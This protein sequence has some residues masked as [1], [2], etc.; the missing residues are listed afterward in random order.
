M[1]GRGKLSSGKLIVCNK[2]LPETVRDVESLKERASLYGCSQE[3]NSALRK[4]ESSLGKLKRHRPIKLVVILLVR[5]PYIVIGSSSEIELCPYII[6]FQQ[7][8]ATSLG[9]DS[10]V[11]AAGHEHSMS[12]SLLAQ[13]SGQQSSSHIVK[14]T[15]IGAGSLGSKIA[16]HLART[17]KGPNIVVDQSH[18]SPHNAARHA[19]IPPKEDSQNGW[20]GSKATL[21]THAIEGLDQQAKALDVD[22]TEYLLNE[23][24]VKKICTKDS[25]AIVDTTGSHTVR[26]ALGASETL[27][28]RVIEA[29]LLARGHVGVVMAEGED[30][31]PNICDLEAEC[32]SI[33]HENRELGEIVFD[34]NDAV[35]RQSTGQGCGS[36]TMV[37]SDSRSSLMASSISEYISKRQRNGLPKRNGEILIGRLCEDGLSVVWKSWEVS[38][39]YVVRSNKNTN[40]RI[41]IHERAMSKMNEETERHPDEETGGVI[42]G[43]LSEVS[44]TAHVVDVIDAPEDSIRSQ[45]GFVL[46]TIGLEPFLNRY[47]DCVNGTLYCLGTW[48]SHLTSHGPSNTDLN[49]AADVASSRSIPAIFLIHTPSKVLAHVAETK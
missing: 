17:G 4:F 6:D 28:A 34:N 3:L 7:P 20:Y 36:M 18:M 47:T 2:Y 13:M 5:R 44:R 10:V 46:G 35:S 25:W 8:S 32:Y 48:H 15:L 11:S 27:P 33:I 42:V 39:V 30:R 49:T 21:L 31:N 43:R 40:W 45:G 26:Q 1:L 16:L 29:S 23:K 24:S 19:L 12:R 38:P 14:W 41:H 37:L 22:I 9:S